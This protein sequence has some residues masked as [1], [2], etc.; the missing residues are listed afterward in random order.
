[1]I[2]DWLQEGQPAT[3]PHG[4]RIALRFSTDEL[5]KIFGR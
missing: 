4:R 2:D 5:A 3:C 1:L